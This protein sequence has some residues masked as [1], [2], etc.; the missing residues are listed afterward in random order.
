IYVFFFSSRRRHTR[1]KRDWSSDVCS[2]DL[3]PQG[4]YAVIQEFNGLYSMPLLAIVLVGFYSKKTSATGAKIALVFHIVVYA[5]SKVV[6][7]EIHYLYV[8]SVLFLLYLAILY[9]Y[10]KKKPSQEDFQFDKYTN[11]VDITP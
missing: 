6:I 10:S 7:P 9:F 1:S 3:F 2:S 8:W 11:K 5:L 4:L